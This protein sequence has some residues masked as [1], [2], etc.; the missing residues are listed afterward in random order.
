MT[1]SSRCDV[2]IVGAGLAGLRAA[3]ILSHYDLEVVVVE[4]ADHVG[5]RVHSFDVDG[6]IVDEGFQL[7]NPGYPELVATGV[8]ASLDLRS[9]P[10]LLTFVGSREEWT[11][12]DPRRWPLRALTSLRRGRLATTDAARLARLLATA[13]WSSTTRLTRVPDRSTRQGFRDLGLREGTIDDV[14]VPFLQGTLLDSELETSWRYTRLLL[15]SLAK[16]RP[17]TPS[18]GARQLPLSLVADAPRVTYRLNEAVREVGAG[19]VRT[20]HGEIRAR[21][22]LV[23]A[24][25]SEAAKLLSGRDHGWRATTTWWFDTPRV[26]SGERLRLD[27]DRRVVASML[28]VASVAPE[29]APR[30]RSLIA[31][32]VNGEHDARLDDE[33]AQDVGRFYDV[34]RGDV[35]LVA[36]TTVARA[37]PKLM[38]P[39]DLRGPSRRGSV[40]VA[41]DYLQTP[42]IQ[43][44]LVSGRRAAHA[45]R[46]SL[47]TA[48]VA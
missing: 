25:Q 1:A 37:L 41:G 12:A 2:V 18:N 30:G 33:M 29:R 22:T 40:F 23:A 28:D 39:L 20:D 9:I 10:G 7:I 15:K 48:D 11:F 45:I 35:T 24:D 5:G 46:K 47:G 26:A 6:F 21:A 43:G 44:A 36:R 34:A 16:G 4:R 31:V 19:F 38:P 32:A 42:S 14:I 3:Q 17:G 27:V 8:L 13:R